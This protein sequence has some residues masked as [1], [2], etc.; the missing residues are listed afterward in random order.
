MKMKFGFQKIRFKYENKILRDKTR[1]GAKDKFKVEVYFIVLNWLFTFNMS[2]FEGLR[3]NLS[4]LSVLL[5]DWLIIAINK[6][7]PV[8]QDNFMYLEK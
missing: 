2:Q 7:D 4:T 3:K 6:G 8:H 1:D 5:V